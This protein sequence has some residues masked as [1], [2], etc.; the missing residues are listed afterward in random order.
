MSVGSRIKEARL[1]ANITQE[2]L[3]AL[4]NVSKGA[5]GNYENDTNYPKTEIIFELCSILKCDPNYLYQDDI[6]ETTG[7]QVA[8]PEQKMLI[9][10]R[11]LD[12]YGKDMVDMV[13]KKEFQ[14]CSDQQR[15]ETRNNVPSP[16]LIS[17]QVYDDPAAAGA[18]LDATSASTRID[19]PE[20]VV[21]SDADYGVRISGDSM[22][23]TIPD[24]SIVFVRKAQTAHNRDIVIAWVESE[25][26]MVCKRAVCDGDRLLRLESANVMYLDITG[27][28]L[29]DLRIYGV[30]VGHTEG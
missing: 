10:Y 1:R 2:Q 8:F 3:A 24:G 6:K 15:E 13:L 17:L 29:N 9:Q 4:L 12:E 20:E 19:F 7:F 27:N 16:R 21:P 28:Q 11:S 14:R 25:G 5:I 30:V 18:P 23:P 22:E 26:G